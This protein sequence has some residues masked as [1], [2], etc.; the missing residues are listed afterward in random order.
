MGDT[1]VDNLGTVRSHQNIRG[2]EV[3]VN[4]TDRIHGHQGFRQPHCQSN[5]LI[6]LQRAVGSHV[7]EEVPTFD[8]FGNQVRMLRNQV[9]IHVPSCTDTSHPL[10]RLNFPAKSSPKAWVIGQLGTKELESELDPRAVL[11]QKHDPHA[12]RPDTAQRT[13]RADDPGVGS[14]EIFHMREL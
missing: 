2:L 4:D 8:V 6:P 11:Y 7:V 1:E 5:E 9:G 3:P 14:M 10:T 13:V 12:A